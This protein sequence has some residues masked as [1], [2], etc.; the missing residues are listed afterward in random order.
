MKLNA[1]SLNAKLYCWFYGEPTRKLPNNLCPYFWKLVLAWV[2]LV[3]YAVITIPVVLVELFSKGYEN[4]DNKTLSRIGIS[5]VIYVGLFVLLCMGTAVATLFTTFAKGSFLGEIWF[6]G[7]LFWMFAI[8]MGGYHGTKALVEYIKESRI[9]R[10]EHGYRIYTDNKE[11][12]PN[13]IVE[14]TK[15]KYNK[16]CPKID[17][18]NRD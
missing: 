10:D 2:L 12:K 8:G 6:G 18:T 5:L 11:K 17:W 13:L 15:A 7:V 3:P 4:G 1:N 9:P 14:F 16:Y